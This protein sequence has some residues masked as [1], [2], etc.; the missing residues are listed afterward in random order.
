MIKEFNKIDYRF[1]H[2]KDYVNDLIKY[3]A[4]SCDHIIPPIHDVKK[5]FLEKV[6]D[7]EENRSY[8]KILIVGLMSSVN[9]SQLDILRKYVFPTIEN[10]VSN[11]KIQFHFIGIAYDNLPDDFKEKDYVIARGY[12]EDIYTELNNCDLLFSVTP[13]P[14]GFRVRLAEALS[15][16][17][18]ILTTKFDQVS[19][20]FLKDNHNC[21][22][23][24]D[25]KNTGRKILEIIESK[26]KNIYIKQNAREA[27]VK[28]LSYETAG[29]KY[30]SLFL[31]N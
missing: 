17:T 6:K 13:R 21:Y 8:Y 1:T 29:K 31:K 5:N 14:F 28:N 18:C 30:E 25:I 20:P 26:E 3:G 12:V 2:S 23:I 15:I 24:D 16:G 22:I 11:K 9:L 4:I 27:Y 7:T 19:L 10:N